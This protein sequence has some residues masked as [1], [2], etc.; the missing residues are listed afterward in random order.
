MGRVAERVAVASPPDGA[1]VVAAGVVELAAG[2]CESIARVSGLDQ[3][4]VRGVAMQA[5]ALR[6]RSAFL[7]AANG[8]AY[9]VARAEL[10]RTPAPGETGRD[11]AL[12]AALVA[13]ANTVA[14]IAAVAADCAGV[15]AEV[16][17]LC[18]PA[19]RTDAAGAAELAGAAA[20]TAASLTNVNLA[21]LP[22][23]ARRARVAEALSAA[24]GACQRARR[25]AGLGES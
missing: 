2:L 1:G 19:L 4:D 23:D 9:A 16:A 11:A 25:E 5:I 18:D 15:A 20:R 22:S 17:R 3:V 7:R 14:G 21:L 10:E 12:R 6:E 13:A 8:R 24:A